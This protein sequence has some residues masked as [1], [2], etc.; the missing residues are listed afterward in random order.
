MR[1]KIAAGT[2]ALATL[3]TTS[4]FP[5]GQGA[6]S[7]PAPPPATLASPP[8]RI[9]VGGNVQ[10]AKMIRQVPAPERA[11]A[12]DF[13]GVW[14]F[15][16]PSFVRMKLEFRLDGA[17]IF[18]LFG[19]GSGSYSHVG[20]S[21]NVSQV[22]YRAP[23]VWQVHINGDSLSLRL[24]ADLPACPFRRIG[25]AESSTDPLIGMWRS[26]PCDVPVENITGFTLKAFVSNATYTFTADGTLR[27]RY[28]YDEVAQYAIQDGKISCPTL[29][30]KGA[31]FRLRVEGGTPTLVGNSSQILEKQTLGQ[32]LADQY[33]QGD[34]SEENVRFR[35]QAI[36]EYMTELK[37]DPRDLGAIDGLGAILF[38]MA[39]Q[40]FDA[41]KAEESKGYFQKHIQLKPQ[42]PEAYDWVGAI[43]WILASRANA[44]L[45]RTY[46]VAYDGNPIKNNGA[47]PTSVRTEYAVKYG[48]IV[49]EGISNLQ[50]AIAIDAGYRDAIAYLGLLY[51]I[52]A[53]WVET[54]A[55]RANLL[56]Q[57]NDLIAKAN[58]AQNASATGQ[59]AGSRE[60][61][62][63]LTA[64]PSPPV[65]GLVGPVAVSPG[66]V[67]REA[68]RGLPEARGEA[69]AGEN[70]R[71]P[72]ALFHPR[73]LSAG[74][75]LLTPNEGVDFSKYLTQL[76]AS[77]K[78]NW[79]AVMRESARLGEKGK[80]VVQFHIEPDG[81]V[82]P[83]EPVLVAGSG[84]EDFDRAVLAA[85]RTSSPFERLPTDFHGPFIE[86]RC[87][88]LYNLARSGR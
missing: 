40:P 14:H 84:R 16:G 74:F 50:K 38:Q 60:R 83:Q 59:S 46:N 53:D 7:N 43:D 71:S 68:V 3:L 12:S 86:L 80:V 35:D 25:S 28:H 29:F 33:I 77:V 62:L 70:A 82:P 23:S 30:M 63:S 78:R 76:M 27:I 10:S 81:S 48:A 57:A 55:E 37:K 61:R 73:E 75:S 21:V 24:I 52:K 15:L 49:D 41:R 65:G 1:W 6:S 4:A 56:A 22:G 44:D 34:P 18:S 32:Q 19:G 42:D 85:I 26:E 64:P 45:H 5:Q 51:R 87:T 2:L 13:E 54:P 11:T 36:A 72:F 31:D 20:D 66:Q 67:I 88:V 17:C 39:L 9:R 79:S 47:I 8:M 69:V 58:S